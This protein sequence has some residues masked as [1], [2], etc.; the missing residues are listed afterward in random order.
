MVIAARRISNRKV[1]IPGQVVWMIGGGV[2][3]ALIALLTISLM[4]NPFPSQDLEIYDWITGLNVVGLAG[5][6][7]SVSLLTDAKVAVAYGLAGVAVLLYLKQP[8]LA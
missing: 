1:S 3:A 2:L 8:K 5:F 6:F 4:N 7:K